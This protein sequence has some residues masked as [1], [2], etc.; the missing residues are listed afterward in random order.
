MGIVKKL[1]G[2]LSRPDKIEH[3]VVDL[4]TGKKLK[5]IKV[6][7]PDGSYTLSRLDEEV[8]MPEAKEPELTEKPERRETRSRR[9]RESDEIGMAEDR[10]VRKDLLDLLDE[11]ITAAVS[12]KEDRDELR[13]RVRELEADLEEIEEHKVARRDA[14]T[15]LGDVAESAI[16][17]KDEK[18]SLEES[19]DRLKAERSA[20]EDK[21]RQ[22]EKVLLNI[23][24][25]VIDFDR[26]IK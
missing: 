4:K 1:K 3:E 18:A 2:K 15:R 25:K 12:I 21:I 23:K 16:A 8:R 24:E 5:L 7:Q 6:K 13:A 26:K 14:E 22:Y 10:T 9:A 20:V 19:I 17:L 11:D